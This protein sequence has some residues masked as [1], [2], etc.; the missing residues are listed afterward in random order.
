MLIL[1]KFLG[2]FNVTATKISDFCRKLKADSKIYIYYK[3]LE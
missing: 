2:K 1:A 3:E